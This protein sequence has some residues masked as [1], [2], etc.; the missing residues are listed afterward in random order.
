MA[1]QLIEAAAVAR[2]TGRARWALAHALMHRG[3]LAEAE[4]EAEKARLLLAPLRIDH[5]GASAT[6][7][8]IQLAAGR[9][10]EALATAEAA[11]A[12]YGRLGACGFFRGPYLRVVHIEAL[13]AAGREHEAREAIAIAH[14]KLLLLADRITVP[15]YRSSFLEV[16]PENVRTLELAR[17]W[18]R[19]PSG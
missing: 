5:V 7:A 17:L 8:G 1:K 11:M 19:V 18:P 10:E 15:R 12:D 2:D 13:L 9:V 16:V 3:D 14:E 6:L 4:R